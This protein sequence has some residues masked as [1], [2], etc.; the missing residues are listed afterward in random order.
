MAQADEFAYCTTKNEDLENMIICKTHIGATNC[1]QTMKQY[2]WNRTAE[3]I[4]NINLNLTWQK[5]MIAA[6]VIAGVEDPANIF[7]VSNRLYGQRPAIKF[8]E[9]SGA[10]VMA[11]KWTPGMLTN[12]ITKTFVEPRVVIVT[13]PRLDHLAI[14]EASYVNIP[15]IALC[16]TDSPTK[17]VDIAI[18]CNNKAKESLALI[19][20]MLLREVL[21][22]R[23]A[24]KRTEGFKMMMDLF[25]H[26]MTEEEEK[27]QEEEK[28]KM[29][30]PI[31]EEPKEAEK[32]QEPAATSEVKPEF[33]N[34]WENKTVTA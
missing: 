7:I 32:P 13:D 11:T 18:P 29:A 9:Y 20:F 34:T 27:K 25:V 12:Q 23:G 1:T 33:E 6:R 4:F 21:Y 17:G 15:V 19:L 14:K 10:R 26:K 3:G 2:V 28:E 8:A 22:L 30:E 31:P 24:V 16:D 5:L